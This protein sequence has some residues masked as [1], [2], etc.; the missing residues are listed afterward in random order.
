MAKKAPAARAI[1]ATDPIF[2]INKRVEWLMLTLAD[3]LVELGISQIETLPA[4][5]PDRKLLLE[6]YAKRGKGGLPPEK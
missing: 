4:W 6:Y 1:A 5:H 3:E 2:D